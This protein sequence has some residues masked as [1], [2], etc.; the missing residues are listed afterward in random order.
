MKGPGLDL[1]AL[2]G[3]ITMPPQTMSTSTGPRPPPE[4]VA[5]DISDIVEQVTDDTAMEDN[6]G[7]KEVDVSS[8]TTKKTT[9]GKKKKAVEINL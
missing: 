8:K 6:D 5:D 3:N 9:R 7:I 4:D 2:M 1:G